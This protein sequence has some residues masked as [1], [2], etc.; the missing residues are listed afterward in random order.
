[1]YVGEIMIALGLDFETTGLDTSTC[2]ILEVGVARC[3]GKS[4]IDMSSW[5]VRQPDSFLTH[6]VQQISSFRIDL[7]KEFGYDELAVMKRLNHMMNSC[8]YVVAYNGRDYDMDVYY[9]TCNRLELASVDKLWVDPLKDIDFPP[10]IHGRKLVHVAAEHGFLNPFAHRALFDVVTM[11]QI[12]S[13][14]DEETVVACARAPRVRI[15]ALGLP[16]HLRE[17][18]KK[19]GYKWDSDNKIW[20]LEMRDLADNVEQECNECGFKIKVETCV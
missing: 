14:Y 12:Y 20:Y 7:V 17:L 18:A 8:D 4:I 5:L 10:H 19:R 2:R 3:L 13:N 6:E 11:M 16:Y 15:E 9:N 1:M